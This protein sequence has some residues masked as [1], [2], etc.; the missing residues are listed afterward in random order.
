MI[1]GLQIPHKQIMAWYLT[2]NSM[3]SDSLWDVTKTVIKTLNENGIFVLV[4]NS[5]MGSANVSVWREAEISVKET[6]R[7][8]INHPS[9]DN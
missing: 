8:F 4:A 1:K 9:I 3:K 7:T 5:D 2:S 6:C